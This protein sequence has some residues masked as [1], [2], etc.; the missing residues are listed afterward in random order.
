[1][2]IDGITTVSKVNDNKAI[3]LPKKLSEKI[4]WKIGDRLILTIIKKD[5]DSIENLLVVPADNIKISAGVEIKE[6]KV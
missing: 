3:V 2:G 1:M 6:V 4:N 5:S